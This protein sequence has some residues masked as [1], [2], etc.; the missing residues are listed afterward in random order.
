MS[1]DVASL[2]SAGALLATTVIGWWFFFGVFGPAVAGTLLG[3]SK[4]I[5][6]ARPQRPDWTTSE[7][8]D[9]DLHVRVK[10]RIES[11]RQ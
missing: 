7:F 10:V 8:R 9:N 11:A 2:T 3:E 1:F 6:L 5:T 4:P